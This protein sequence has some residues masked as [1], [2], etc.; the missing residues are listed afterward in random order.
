MILGGARV[1][2]PMGTDAP[3]RR[4]RA[5]RGSIDAPRKRTRAPRWCSDG[6]QQAHACSS[7][8]ERSGSEAQRAKRE[9]NGRAANRGRR[10]KAVPPLPPAREGWGDGSRSGRGGVLTG[11]ACQISRCGISWAYRNLFLQFDPHGGGECLRASGARK[12]PVFRPSMDI[13]KAAS[14]R[15]VE[16]QPVTPVRYAALASGV[17]RDRFAKRVPSAARKASRLWLRPDT[18]SSA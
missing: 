9:R 12:D 11:L 3:R 15:L 10:R 14:L 13:K 7:E 8:E 16:R 18:L 2:L 4:M 17:D 5:R 1:L 6:P